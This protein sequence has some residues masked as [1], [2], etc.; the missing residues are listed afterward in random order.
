MER[1]HKM[2]G[3]IETINKIERGVVV[4]SLASKYFFRD[5][6]E[7]GVEGMPL[8]VWWCGAIVVGPLRSGCGGKWHG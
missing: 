1:V 7:M 3:C 2:E 6:D 4:T 8:N 5:R